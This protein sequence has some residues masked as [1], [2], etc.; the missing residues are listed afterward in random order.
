LARRR[1]DLVAL[2]LVFAW[3][4]MLALL[5]VPPVILAVMLWRWVR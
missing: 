2:A 4:G 5:A 3:Y 1:I